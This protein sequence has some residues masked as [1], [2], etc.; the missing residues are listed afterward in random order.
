MSYTNM[1]IHTGPMRCVAA[2]V[3]ACLVL[4]LVPGELTRVPAADAARSFRPTVLI[5]TEAF[6]NID[7]DDT[8]ANV[9][10]RF[11]DTLA[12]TLIFNRT[13]DR[14]EFN[15]DVYVTGMVRATST[16]SGALLFASQT[17]AS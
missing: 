6:L 4:S 16:V 14:F 13:N 8:T 12:K 2:V 17:L 15:D 10:L 7:D 5:N 9:I 1:H 3:L 11:G